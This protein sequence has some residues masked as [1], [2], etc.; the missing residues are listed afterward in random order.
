MDGY[1]DTEDN[2]RGGLSEMID[3]EVIASRGNSESLW[4]QHGILE[5]RFSDFLR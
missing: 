1:D 5:G 4:K 2:E 3:G